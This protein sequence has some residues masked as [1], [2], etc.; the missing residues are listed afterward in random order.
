MCSHHRMDQTIN[1]RTGGSTFSVF[2][3]V[4]GSLKYL[5]ILCRMTKRVCVQ[6]T[7]DCVISSNMS[8]RYETETPSED[9]TGKWRGWKRIKM[10]ANIFELCLVPNIYLYVKYGCILTSGCV[11]GSSLQGNMCGYLNIVTTCSGALCG[12]WVDHIN[13]PQNLHTCF[14]MYYIVSLFI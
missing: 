9:E 4:E 11:P 3:W 12:K 1:H 5:K 2:R 6:Y 8:G 7:Q 14:H 13:G 10:I